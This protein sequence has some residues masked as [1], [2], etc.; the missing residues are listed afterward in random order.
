MNKQINTII[1]NINFNTPLAQTQKIAAQHTPKQE[2]KL[3]LVK[4]KIYNTPTK[5]PTP[6]AQAS[7]TFTLQPKVE[8]HQRVVNFQI[9]QNS[10]VIK[11]V[12]L[13]PSTNPKVIEIE[14]EMQKLGVKVTFEDDFDTAKIFLKLSKQIKDIGLDLPEKIAF[15]TPIMP[16]ITGH[17]PIDPKLPIY[18]AKDILKNAQKGEVSFKLGEGI[19]T[20]KIRPLEHTFYH[21]IAHYNHLKICPDNKTSAK[22][23]QDFI[24]Q[25][26]I[27]NVIKEVSEGAIKE[28]TGKELVADVMAGLLR[29]KRFSKA[30]MDVYA[31]LNGPKFST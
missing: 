15:F 2:K 18:F 1:F 25:Y 14:Q 23:F 10:S 24:N 27:Q 16:M 19:C 17:T 30:I 5:A 7:A 28:P 13:R 6:T 29:G 4:K 31:A 12:H 11:S 9:P 26:G 8:T 22:I 3:S 21:E 20:V